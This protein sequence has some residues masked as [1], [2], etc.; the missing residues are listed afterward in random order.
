AGRAVVAEEPAD[1]VIADLTPAQLL[2]L[3]GLELPVRYR[4]ALS[5][6]TYGPAIVKIDYLINGPIPWR[7]PEVAR[8]GTVH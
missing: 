4:R 2:R 7:D 5:R 6:W 3:E 1:V 8:A